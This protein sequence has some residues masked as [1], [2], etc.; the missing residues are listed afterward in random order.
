MPV[1]QS[2]G[3]FVSRTLIELISHSRHLREV[4]SHNLVPAFAVFLSLGPI[5][6]IVPQLK[7]LMIALYLEH[8]LPVTILQYNPKSEQA[9][10]LRELAVVFE[11]TEH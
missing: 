5:H 8:F 7:G 2:H 6:R 10:Q 4:L 11:S 3:A 9:E 1:F